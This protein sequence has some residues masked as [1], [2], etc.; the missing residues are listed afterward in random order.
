[1][2]VYEFHLTLGVCMFCCEFHPL[3]NSGTSVLPSSLLLI[4]ADAGYAR[5]WKLL[6]GLSF[7]P[8]V[9][10]V[11]FIVFVSATE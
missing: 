11:P 2:I 1:M 4:M 5:N 3:C 8:A 9:V 6:L 10:V 7:S